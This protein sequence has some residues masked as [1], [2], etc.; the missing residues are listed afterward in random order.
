MPFVEG[1]SL[2]D[3]LVRERQL[4]VEEAVRIVR[5]AAQRAAVR[6][7]TGGGKRMTGLGMTIGTPQYMGPEHA[8]RTDVALAQARSLSAR[9]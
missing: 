1:E 8:M 3:R 4:S 5:E 6:A 9:C 2:R 7:P